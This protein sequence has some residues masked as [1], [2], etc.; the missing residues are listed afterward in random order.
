[1]TR[2]QTLHQKRSSNPLQHA[3]LEVDHERP[4][5]DVRIDMNPNESLR[6][7]MLRFYRDQVGRAKVFNVTSPDCKL[8]MR[9][10][11]PMGNFRINTST[12]IAL[13]VMA[14]LLKAREWGS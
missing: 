2:G 8:L 9:Q 11:P 10:L 12:S 5:G 4:V 7:P 3:Q 1:M 13:P 14:R 6:A